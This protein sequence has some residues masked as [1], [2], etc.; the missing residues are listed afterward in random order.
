MTKRAVLIG[1]NQYEDLSIPSLSGCVADAESM[2]AVLTDCYEFEAHD[3]VLLTAPE[4]TTRKAILDALTGLVDETRRGDVSVVY[5][6]GHG[7]Q[8]PDTSGD[9][10][11]GMDE[12][13]VPSNSH[14]DGGEVL[15]IVDD[16]LHSYVFALAQRTPYTTFIFD[17][18]HSG[19]IDRDLIRPGAIEAIRAE[20][21]PIPR[22]TLPASRPLSVPERPYPGVPEDGGREM[23]ASGLIRQGDYALLAG[24]P[25]DEVSIEA[26]FEGQMHGLLTKFLV[27]NLRSEPNATVGAVA[28]KV[29]VE[30]EADARRREK[31]QRPVFEAPPRLRDAIPFSGNDATREDPAN[32]GNE[33]KPSQGQV[34]SPDNQDQAGDKPPQST[35]SPGQDDGNPGTKPPLLREWDVKFAKA[36]AGVLIGMLVLAGTVFLLLT[37][38]ALDGL[39]GSTKI[40]TTF[41]VELLLT[42][43][44][45]GGAGVYIALL[46]QR[47]RSHALE[48]VLAAAAKPAQRSPEA[49]E[50]G[51][52]I[53]SDEIKG[54]FEALGKMPTARGL[55]AVGGLIAIGAI[56]L[57]WHVLPESQ[58][59]KAPTI[60]KQPKAASVVASGRALFVVSADGSD[61]GYEWK[62]NGKPVA[63]ATD[64]PTLAVGP[65]RRAQSGALYTVTVN[66]ENGQ[67]TSEGAKLTVKKKR[68]NRGAKGG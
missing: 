62:R 9:E 14:R 13:I 54:T 17:S 19:S 22:A 49:G 46:D 31:R 11:D 8:V 28:A 12:T 32:A 59:G 39:D 53:G 27:D 44:L 3:L 15:D 52:G 45:I 1:I 55:I 30:V 60:S 36:C 41:A 24:C 5:Y 29:K 4:Q 66:N 26:S 58:A 18:C 16:E 56:A 35:A 10:E 65:V 50:K 37:G 43:L 47:G 25:D 2:A 51:I 38:S 6:S 23:S 40:A 48:N 21:R 34:A 61:L 57:A 67:A 63:E 7:S 68:K 42:G 20:S 64:S 33:P